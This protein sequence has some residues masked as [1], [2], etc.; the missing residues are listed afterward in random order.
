MSLPRDFTHRGRAARWLR[1]AR[2]AR[3]AARR[4]VQAGD[5]AV[6]YG[7]HS[8]TA[9]TGTAV[10]AWARAGRLYA[11]ALAHM[12]RREECLRR[13]RGKR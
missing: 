12:D 13:A 5:E 1:R 10:T 6:R 3:N 8:Y 2:I 7:W 11:K 9:D 4:E